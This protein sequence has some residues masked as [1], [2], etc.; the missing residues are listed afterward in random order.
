M[1]VA[2]LVGAEVRSDRVGSLSVDYT[3]R[4]GLEAKKA[5]A[6]PLLSF[7]STVFAA[8]VCAACHLILS[9]SAHRGIDGL[10]VGQL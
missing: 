10:Q 9:V 6:Y 8:F 2:L 5:L 4:V 3:V 7:S 1:C